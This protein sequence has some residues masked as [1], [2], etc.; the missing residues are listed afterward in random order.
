ME[1][2]LPAI[3]RHAARQEGQCVNLHD[4]ILRRDRMVDSF[5]G[6]EAA[7]LKLAGGGQRAI[8]LQRNATLRLCRAD[9]AT[10]IKH[11]PTLPG[12]QVRLEPGASLEVWL[13]CP[14][15]AHRLFHSGAMTECEVTLVWPVPVP[16]R[17]DLR[18]SVLGEGA[19]VAV[20]PLFNARTRLLPL[21]RGRGVEVGPGANPAVMPSEAVDVT[22]LE[23]MPAEDWARVYAK[24]QLPGAVA[25]LWKRYVV[26]SAHRMESF[27]QSSL[28][29]V[30]SSHVIEHLV[31]PL[32]VFENWWEKL[33]PGGVLAGVIPDAR[34]T[35]D[36]RQ[37]VTTREELLAQFDE[38]SFD[39]NEAMYV[40]WCGKT[41]PENTPASL[42]ARNYSIH[43]A[44][45]TP[46]SFRDFIELFG[47]RRP[48]S[49]VFIESVAN[50]KDFG[51]LI[52]KP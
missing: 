31:N 23:R 13:E 24:Q 26:D 19:T 35:F 52:R 5:E 30:F 39:P 4:I 3:R 45:Y 1:A 11:F 42:R 9:E 18:L 36:L 8:R 51:F 47:A 38:G 32:G 49:G 21:L 27:G 2:A 37:D 48:L 46:Q 41:S 10:A 7:I 34:Y 17:Y 28:Q 50:G 22:Y 12:W 14:G 43:V 15:G 40:K 29:F 25:D 20:G 16:T 6:V 33:A 44:Y